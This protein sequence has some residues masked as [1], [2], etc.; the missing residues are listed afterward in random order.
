MVKSKNDEDIDRAYPV[1]RSAQVLVP[2][3]VDARS[4]MSSEQ[5]HDDVIHK[6][7]A[8]H[9]PYPDKLIHEVFEEQAARSP[10]SAAVICGDQSLTFAELNSRANQVAR[11]LADRAIGPDELVGICVER[12]LEMVVGMLGV[13]KAGGAYV[14]L[15]PD[16]PA[17]RLHHTIEDAAPRVVLLQEKLRPR[18]PAAQVEVIALDSDWQR[19][20][21]YSCANR[22]ARATG[23]RTDQ[24]A[25]VIYTSGSTGRPKGVMIE[26]RNVL[27][28]W[29]GLEPMYDRS[30]PC[31]RV[32]VNASFNF[33]ASVKQFI[34][35]LSGRAVVLVPQEARWDAALLLDFIDKQRVDSI[36]CTPWQLRSWVA[37]GLLESGGSH[38]LRL[39]LVGGEP[40][41]SELWRRLAM[42]SRTD[43]YN[44]YGPTES[45]VDTTYACLRG[46]LSGPHIGPPMQNRQ[47]HIL[48]EHAQVLPVGVAGE[49]HIGGAGVA[50]GYLNQPELT[51]ARFVRNP[52]HA[53]SNARMYCTGDI[54]R[55]RADGAIEYLGRNDQ[56]VKIRGFRIELG[57]IEAQLYQHELVREAAVVV[58]DDIPGESRLV[59]YV[60]PNSPKLRDWHDRRGSE[61][62]SDQMVMEWQTVHE[63]TYEFHG[64]ASGPSFGGW[65]SSYTGKPIAL[66]DME[67]W[68]RCTIDRVGKLAPR[69]VLEI[70]CGVGLVLQHLAPQ[71]ENYWG[72]DFSAVA[73]Q[74]LNGWLQ[75]QPTLSDVKLL[76]RTATEFA[77]LP[78]DS[79]DTVV[80]NSVVQYFPDVNYLLEVLA[81]AVKLLG[82]GGRIFVGDVRHFGLLEVFHSSVQFARAADDVNVGKLRS[83]IARVVEQEKELVLDPEFFMSLPRYLPDITEVE[84]QLKRGAADNELTR[85]RYDVVLHVRGT[86]VSPDEVSIPWV[87]EQS[88]NAQLDMHVATGKADALRIDH[89]LNRRLFADLSAWELV[90]CSDEHVPVRAIRAQVSQSGTDPEEFFSWADNNGFEVQV[91]WGSPRAL[92]EF[93]VRLWRRGTRVYR[94]TSQSVTDALALRE[95]SASHD[96]ALA[97][98]NDP[99]I[100][101]LKQ[102]L[103]VQLREW[104]AQRLPEYMVPAAY[105][106]LD[107]LPMTPNG[108]LDR[109]ALPAPE[110]GSFANRHYVAPQGEVEEILAGIWQELLHLERVGRHDSFFELG[111]HSLLIMQMLGRL[112]R[113]GLSIQVHRVFENPTLAELAGALTS[114]AI[115]DCSVPLNLIPAGCSEI[116]PQMITLVHL[117]R[118]HIAAIVSRIPGAAVNIQD[119]YPLTPLQEGILF[120]H[121]LDHES[122]DAYVLPTL[123]AVESR[124]RLDALIGALQSIV[125]RHDVLR[126]AVLW[127]EL[128]RPV[129]VVLRHATLPVEELVLDVSAD[130]RQQVMAWID[131]KQQR[132]DLRHAPLM[133]LR[134]AADPNGPQWYVRFQLHH[135]ICDHESAQMVIAELLALL[136]GD[137]AS[138]PETAPYRNHVARVLEHA[139]I[140]NAE[141]FFRS[142]LGDV[143]EPTAPF[144]LLNVQGDGTQ[145]VE[146]RR[147]CEMDLSQ[148]IRLRARRLGVSA[149][150]IFHAAW[151][152]VVALTTGK[153]DVVFGSV[154]LGRLQGNDAEQRMMG[155]FVNTLPVRL[156][157]RRLSVKDLVEYTQHELVQLLR[158]EQASLALAHRCS[159]IEGT[160]PL[161]TSLLNY[162][163]NV[164]AAEGGWP[165]G[166]GVEVLASHY[167]TNYPITL[168]VDDLGEGFRLTAHTD[169][170]IDPQRMI[171]YLH[172]ALSSLV[173][174]LEETPALAAQDLAVLAERERHQIFESFNSTSV[175]YPAQRVVHE[176]F[177]EQAART[178]NAIAVVHENR[179][180]T[181][182]ELNESANLLAHYLQSTGIGPDELVGVCVERTPEMLIGLLAILKAGGAYLPLDPHYPRER[183]EYM[184]ADAAPR[185]VFMQERLRSL[186]PPTTAEMV[187]LDK[188]P[189]SAVSGDPQNI[190]PAVI[191]LTPRNLVYVIYTSGSTG[192]PKGTAMAHA[193]MVN[194]IEWHRAN[195]P[196]HTG[197]RVLQFAALSFDV[198]FQEIFTT[199]CLG[200]TLVLID[201]WIRKDV[202]ALTEFLER[203][204]VERL[205]LP[206]LMLQTLAECAATSSARF[207]LRDVITAGEQLR[208]SSE[209]VD[210][211]KRLP[212]SRLHN[213]YGPTES[214]VVTALTLAGDP[215]SWPTL[216]SI[217]RPISN[218]HIHILN[219]RCRPVPVGVAGEIF[220]GGIGVAR[221]YLRRE[222]LTAQRFVDDPFSSRPGQTLYRTGDLGCWTSDGAI[223][224]LGRNDFQVKIR[225][226]RI[227]LGEVEAQIVRHPQVKEAAVIAREDVPGQKRLVAYVVPTQGATISALDLQTFVKRAL[228]DH[229]VP[230]ALVL[231][232]RM[233]LT[234][235]GKLDRRALP[236]PDV[237]DFGDAEYTAPQGAIEKVLAKIWGDL[238][239]L[240]QVGRGA[241]FFALGGHSLLAMQAAVRIRSALSIEVPVR[242]LFDAPTVE[243]LAA[244]IEESSQ[245]QLVNSIAEDSDD[246]E[247]LLERVSAMSESQV[248]VLMQELRAEGRQ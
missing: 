90:N 95:G 116:T 169:R 74:R 204:S 146:A 150:T 14:P 109:R 69:N 89:V 79:L 173:R 229:M 192:Q 61:G 2:D 191:A 241:N 72:S 54:G 243:Q 122:G 39:V 131:P 91:V 10:N 75:T 206:P 213:H 230:G 149:A 145:I 119:I 15:D 55:W 186:L 18:L 238:L 194:L 37:A 242:M 60:V 137:G 235:N 124:Q 200:G 93:A 218:T 153:D 232:E 216:P 203:W 244:R 23:Q 176:L 103:P 71:C 108:K 155:M 188:P 62:L 223:E 120:H 70:G 121:V 197:E 154:L 17:D 189:R 41:D 181:Y 110:L 178:P 46:D 30:G 245:R 7:N 170:R 152:V 87:A 85:Y 56:Q 182:A 31:K 148:R 156:Q 166:C 212:A 77:G 1:D 26:H 115:G 132:M 4:A 151:G 187:S 199:L 68:L 141:K 6:F 143:D 168:T 96:W 179:S 160:A 102:V 138:L 101:R 104:L 224:Y 67:E 84:I 190:S 25:Y 144:G 174:A 184:L 217:G 43:F 157:L 111:G 112:R 97:Y 33:D 16:Y 195:L 11:Y 80:I 239:R 205:F 49:I 163:H 94:G 225:G 172:T 140:D 130:V 12:S 88:V 36:D 139:R 167:R 8:T 185:V 57:E 3:N 183:L 53:D 59:A 136:E 202:H 248:E 142:K 22:D 47:V 48:D 42:S 165:S 240:E 9:A 78:T 231:L 32:A 220:I 128:P 226:F 123:F 228:P 20:A 51:A 118:E 214:H 107:S 65:D 81:G 198:A 63:S 219:D 159:G 86:H 117:D 221:G 29:Q 38:Q 237:A 28:L 175:H 66:R 233:P 24:L 207:E 27:S 234:P 246:I 5:E 83:R 64:I 99:L 126:T 209:I 58:R 215:T 208:I 129:Q 92:G 134:I 44:V 100:G 113:V 34:Q 201:E 82:A 222:Q 73:L 164:P 180:L 147:E 162:E 127:E 45:T 161:F 13:L 196:V 125:Q 50:R 158:H 193:S 135:M 106:N 40:I 227:E 105:V 98:A 247:E 19:I 21:E 236:A 177:E 35:L 171:D 211:F 210:L 114:E 76:H 133:R 52:F